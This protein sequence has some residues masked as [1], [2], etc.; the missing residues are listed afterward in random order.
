MRRRSVLLVSVS[1]RSL[2]FTMQPPPH[3][4]VYLGFYSLFSVTEEPFVTSG[5]NPPLTPFHTLVPKPF[6]R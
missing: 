2:F 1:Y 4:H 6:T 5:G 3:I